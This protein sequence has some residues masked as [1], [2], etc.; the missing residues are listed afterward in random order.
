MN[1]E[2]LGWISR[3][4]DSSLVERQTRDRKVAGLSPSRSSRRIFFFNVNFVSTL[5]SY[6]GIVSTPVLPH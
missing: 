6:F 2:G 5:K 1:S 3:G 4:G